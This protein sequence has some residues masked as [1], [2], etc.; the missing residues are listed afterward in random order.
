MIVATASGPF[1]ATVG[2]AI[3]NL[4]G[5]IA[6]QVEDVDGNIVIAASTAN[7][8]E[9][10]DDASNPTG[11]Y[12]AHRTAPGTDGSYVVVWSTDGTFDA[13][14][15]ASEDMTVIAGAVTPVLPPIPVAP[16]PGPTAGPCQSW[17]T[18]EQAADCCTGLDIGSDFALLDEAAVAAS[19][20]LYELSG[21]KYPGVCSQTVRPCSTPC[22]GWGSIAGFPSQAWG[23]LAGG[24]GFNG[25]WG[26]W[27][28]DGQ[29]LCGCQPISTVELPGYPAVEITQVK[30]DGEVLP[31]V[32]IDGDPTYRLDDWA[33]LVRLYK[34][35][36]DGAPAQPR[37]WPSC[38]N[39]AL[40]DDQPGTFAVTYNYG[41]APP[42]PG[43]LAAEQL[44]CEIYKSCHGLDCKLPNG[45]TK[46]TRQ[47]ISIERLLT[48]WN[49]QLG[50]YGINPGSWTT[51]MALVDVF[52][53]TYNPYAKRRRSVVWTP[54]VQQPARRVG[55]T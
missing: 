51:G 36:V 13:P 49:L 28:G 8:L 9:L 54:D 32:D 45:T 1:T 4:V 18:S 35:G 43:I 7:I 40:A 23:G 46:I 30:I 41:V 39:L 19:M 24:W 17:I 10:D 47:G 2:T 53:A 50:R 52:L 26:W 27:G 5:T 33:Q 16:G 29:A 55:S 11:V 42:L 48:V 37:W 12:V 14:T 38:Q 44:A 25:S 3:P 15:V 21:R 20:I 31:A 34:P 22:A 6:I